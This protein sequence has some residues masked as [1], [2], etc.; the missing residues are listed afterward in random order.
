MVTAGRSRADGRTYS[1]FRYKE[2]CLSDPLLCP[3]LAPPIYLT[4]KEARGTLRS[5]TIEKWSL[6]GRSSREK[7]EEREEK[8][9]SSDSSRPRDS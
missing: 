2:L 5:E 8:L 6:S 3:S 9:P 7:R 1:A 4:L